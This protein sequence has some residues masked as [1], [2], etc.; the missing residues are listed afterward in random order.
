MKTDQKS[1][2]EFDIKREEMPQEGS[3]MKNERKPKEEFDIKHEEMPDEESA[4]K[5]RQ[6]R[7]MS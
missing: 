1:K 4:S 5:F 6:L 3:I 7:E 2:V